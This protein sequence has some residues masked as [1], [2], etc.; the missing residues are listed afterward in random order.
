MGSVIAIFSPTGGVGVSTVACHLAQ[1]LSP[2]SETALVDMVYDFGSQTDF[3]GFTPRSTSGKFPLLF[4]PDSPVLSE[5]CLPRR[6]QLKLFVLPPAAV[7]QALDWTAFFTSSRKTFNYTILDL[8]HTF[9]APELSVGLA[10]AEQILVIGE[11]HWAT[12]NSLRAFFDGC[13]ENIAGKCKVVINRSE[14]LPEDVL[15]EC[16]NDLNKPIFAELPYDSKLDGTRKLN[17]HSIFWGA[18]KKLCLNLLPEAAS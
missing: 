11:Y 2:T 8:P 1:Q 16:L 5:L 17:E 14:W 12:I 6:Q 13:D 4:G 10:Q 7:S 15:S 9:L 18:L 3:L